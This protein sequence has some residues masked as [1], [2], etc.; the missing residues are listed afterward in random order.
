MKNWFTQTR[1]TAAEEP[2]M[3][4]QHGDFRLIST[5]FFLASLVLTSV[6][7]YYTELQLMYVVVFFRFTLKPI[8]VVGRRTGFS[9]WLLFF[10]ISS[11]WRNARARLHH[12]FSSVEIITETFLFCFATNLF[13]SR[14]INRLVCNWGFCFAQISR[15]VSMFV[16]MFFFHTNYYLSTSHNSI[17]KKRRS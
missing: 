2:R 11:I 8:N 12:I 5:L 15:P 13:F 14:I 1:P 16:I 7:N 4:I 10:F 3:H 9:V 6:K 17:R